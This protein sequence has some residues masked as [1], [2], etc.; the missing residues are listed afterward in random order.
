MQNELTR[1][2]R[3]ENFAPNPRIHVQEQRRNIVQEQRIRN[4]GTNEEFRQREPRVPNP[5]V[6]ILEEIFEDEIVDNVNQE[7]DFIQ[8]E[9]LESVQT[10]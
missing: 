9:I 4:D 7:V 5:N 2:R 1:L 6:V 8:E 10:G 3:N